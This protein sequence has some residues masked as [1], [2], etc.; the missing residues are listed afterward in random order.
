MEYIEK[1]IDWLFL[2]CMSNIRCNQNMALS[3]SKFLYRFIEINT[4]YLIF[5]STKSV[6][7]V[8]H[9]NKL[10]INLPLPWF[11]DDFCELLLWC[12]PSSWL[13]LHICYYQKEWREKKRKCWQILPSP[14]LY[15]L[16]FTL[17]VP[18]GDLM[19]GIDDIHT[20]KNVR[21]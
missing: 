16:I 14:I 18:I 5:C 20:H 10:W 12:Q 8:F 1:C 4:S 6:R 9:S 2:I 21:W 19:L 11:Q 13:K 7:I 15:S 17:R 3:A